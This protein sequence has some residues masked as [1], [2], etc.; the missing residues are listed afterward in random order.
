MLVAD[1][2]LFSGS[3][4]KYLSE[5]IADYYGQPLG[6]LKVQKFAD[7]EFQPIIIESVRGTFVFIIQST[8]APSDNLMELLM[9]IDAAKRASATYITA[10]IPYYGYARQD[11]KDQ[12]RVAIASKLVAN[13]LVASGADRVMTMDLHADQIQGFFDIPVDHLHSS[14]IFI[15]YLENKSFENLTFASPDVGSTKR[16]RAYAKYFNAGLVICD[17]YREKANEVAEMNVIGNVEGQDVV[18]VDD[19]VDTANTLCNA[20]NKIMEK[21]AK[22]VTAVCTH[23]VLSGSAL[24]NIE[25]SML[26]ELVVTNTIPLKKESSK[27]KVLSVAKLF[28]KAIRHTHEYK[29][30]NSLFIGSQVF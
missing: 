30:I 9:L 11:R 5:G 16:A 20:A 6:N 25:K 29:S 2:K 8:I 12:P 14:A 26:S 18:L 28:A 24:E 4:S 17:K 27:I 23:A 1:V 3:S 22:S 10:V 7:G 21:G 13:L 15:P 19:I